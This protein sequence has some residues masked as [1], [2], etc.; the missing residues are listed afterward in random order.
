MSKKKKIK[1]NPIF[2]LRK[3]RGHTKR[4]TTALAFLDNG[5]HDGESC[6]RL[7]AVMYDKSVGDVFR[8]WEKFSEVSKK[9]A[10]KR[11]AKQKRRAKL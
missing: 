5:I 4:Y 1:N 9:A 2:Q 3:S 6:L 11:L 7:L 10:R 8:D